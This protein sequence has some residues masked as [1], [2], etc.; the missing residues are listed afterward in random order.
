MAGDPW[1]CR[2]CG[3]GIE[4][5]DHSSGQGKFFCRGTPLQQ[6]FVGQDEPERSE[7][8][9]PTRPAEPAPITCPFCGSRNW[10]LVQAAT[11]A[12]IQVECTHCGARS[13]RHNERGAAL[14]A[15]SRRAL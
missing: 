6:E 9:E 4:D 2:R 12:A 11:T 3:A 14:A 7:Q 5:H 13:S 8:A 1:T 15:W 10:H